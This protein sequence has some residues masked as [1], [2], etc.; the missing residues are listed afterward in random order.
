MEIPALLKRWVKP[1]TFFHQE[2]GNWLCTIDPGS[3]KYPF[4]W[5][6]VTVNEGFGGPAQTYEEA[7]ASIDKALAKK[8]LKRKKKAGQLFER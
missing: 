4:V 5:N 6:I 7:L 2:V 3:E 8:G 1:Y